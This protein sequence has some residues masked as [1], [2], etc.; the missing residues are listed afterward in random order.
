MSYR[1][2]P[3]YK[4]TDVSASTVQNLLQTINSMSQRCRGQANTEDV[5]QR[6]RSIILLYRPHLSN[7]VDLQLPELT[8]EALMPNS[9]NA[10]QITH[11]FNYKYDYNTNVPNA[12]NPF[13]PQPPPS[14]SSSQPQQQPQQQT[15]LQSFTFNA[16]PP[17]SGT[18]ASPPAPTLSTEN[19]TPTQTVVVTAPLSI[20]QSDLATLNVLYVNAQ[21]TPGVASYKQLLRHIVYLVRKYVRYEQITLGLEMLEN[22]DSIQTNN[23]INELLQCIERETNWTIPNGPNVCRWI[24]ILITSFCR[25]VTLITKRELMLSSIKTENKLISIIAEVEN[26]VVT[27]VNA[28]PAA[29]VPVT[30]PPPPPPT[31]TPE[32]EALKNKQ[33]ETLNATVQEQQLEITRMQTRYTSL[34]QQYDTIQSKSLVL[35]NA[36]DRLR[37]Y[38]RSNAAT[39]PPPEDDQQ[40]ILATL[41]YLDELQSTQSQS[42]NAV[43]QQTQALSQQL[44]ISQQLQRELAQTKTQYDEIV[45]KLKR[46]IDENDSYAASINLKLSSFEDTQSQLRAAQVKNEQLQTQIKSLDDSYNRL[47]EENKNLKRKSIAVKPIRKVKA[48]RRNEAQN[49]KLIAETQ[50]LIEEQKSKNQQLQDMK[51]RYNQTI[52]SNAKMLEV[53]KSDALK[54]RSQIESMIGNQAALTASDFKALNT[55]STQNLAD[56]VSLLRAKNQAIE[57]VCNEQLDRESVVLQERLQDSK[58]NLDSKI[59]KL[60]EQVAPLQN[61]IEQSATE[62]EQFKTRIELMGRKEAIKSPK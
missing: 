23:D 1:N 56:Q 12:Y 55:K 59:D 62:I 57:Q 42:V 54:M 41:Q 22:F 46:R 45:A 27:I 28:P 58:T 10:N 53:V 8:M 4:N 15:P 14:S 50:K 38:Y 47:M 18:A 25:I 30:Q 16:V 39:G 49:L 61:R 48:V 13:L 17:Q 24:S 43:S 20:E 36:F 32:V 60:M 40:L 2:V 31:I 11:N 52:D 34:Q 6:V 35:N 9:S 5:L 51:A 7:R 26:A 33:I 19:T 21:R 37:N 29:V 44:E 3:K